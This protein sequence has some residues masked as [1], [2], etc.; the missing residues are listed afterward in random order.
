MRKY[1]LLALILLCSHVYSIEKNKTIYVSTK[2]NDDA[3]GTIKQPVKTLQK[4]AELIKS[5][6]KEN[7]YGKI[8]IILREGIY[9]IVETINLDSILDGNPNLKITFRASLYEEVRLIGGKTINTFKK[10]ID[11]QI[12]NRLKETVRNN[13]Y[14]ADLKTLG[15]KDYGAPP[16]RFDV[17]Y[18]GKFMQV[19]RYPNDGW[20]LIS[21]VPQQ[22]DS[23]YHKGDHKVILNGK[24]AGRHYG[25]IG[26]ED[27]RPDKWQES[28]DIWMHGYW[29]WDWKD[30]FQRIEKIDKENKEIHPAKPFHWYGYEKGQRYYYFNILEEMDQ[31]GEWFFD[32]SSETLYIIPPNK[33]K[34][35]DIMLSVL[36]K[37][38]FRLSNV[39]N[40]S[41]I[42]LIF[43]CSKARAIDIIGGKN[44]LVAGCTIRNIGAD[45]AI[46]IKGGE[47]NG[48]KSCDIYDVGATGITIN[49]GDKVTLSPAG[50]FAINN[51]ITRFA[52]KI[53]A[54]S[55]AIYLY[56]VGNIAAN[57]KIHNAPFSGLQYYGNDHV[58]EYNEIYDISHEAGDVGGINTGADYTDMGIIIRHNLFHHLH[59]PGNG[60]CR[61]VYLDLPGSNATIYGN[62]FCHVDMGVFFN[63]GRDNRVENN[64]FINCHPSINNYDWPHK[65]YFYQGGAWKIWEKMMMYKYDQPPYS[66]KYPILKTYYDST[67]GPIGR[68]VNNV[69]RY[70]ISMGGAFMDLSEEIKLDEI[71]VE[72]NLIADSVLLNLVKKWTIDIDPYAIPYTKTYT[73]DDKDFVDLLTKK[74]NIITKDE[75]KLIDMPNRNFNPKPDSP[76]YKLGFKNIPVEKIGLFKDEYR[77]I[78]PKD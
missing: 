15:I 23:M 68:P 55:A 78:L 41:F 18:R 60:N 26:Y 19:S 58:M 30:D 35:D 25:R 28:N 33:I 66:E 40:V 62:I 54:F 59:G 2:G 4:A 16:H 61:A 75:I 17:L 47:N 14:S 12:L 52:N 3:A 65:N 48:V 24:W 29:V 57:N 42:N 36:D 45:T 27:L 70:N 20:L 67:N 7:N 72:N 63:S 73:Q 38:M 9:Q 34:T 13:V 69:Y 8:E 31:P 49:A 1:F 37:P 76:A 32:K 53:R 10:V 71:I 74:G 39:S 22:G 11:T 6:V 21:S 64:I 46:V 51:H 50:N 44:N 77:K 56:G 5:S 43:E